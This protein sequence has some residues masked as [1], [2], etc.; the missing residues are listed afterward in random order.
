MARPSPGASLGWNTRKRLTGLLNRFTQEEIGK[1]CEITSFLKK[2]S[3]KT[4]GE[5]CFPFCSREMNLFLCP[6]CTCRCGRLCLPG[7]AGLLSLCVQG[8]QGVGLGRGLGWSLG[9]GGGCLQTSRAEL[10][11]EPC[12]RRRPR[13]RAQGSPPRSPGGFRHGLRGAVGSATCSG[14]PGG[15]VGRALWAETQAAALR[16]S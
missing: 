5:K 11:P 4:K 3:K 13:A 7:P 1:G 15:R 14:T 10:L 8:L 12:Q 6:V 2:H 16:L 9:W